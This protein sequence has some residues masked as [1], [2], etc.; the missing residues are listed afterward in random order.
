MSSRKLLNGRVVESPETVVE[1]ELALRALVS[2]Y[3]E[4][5]ANGGVLDF[6]RWVAHVLIYDELV[7]SSSLE[8]DAVRSLKHG[9]VIAFLSAAEMSYEKA[10][11][12]VLEPVSDSV[13]TK[14]AKSRKG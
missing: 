13:C 7:V 8:R 3:A 2:G 10:I 1:A 4:M 14:K 5:Y 6:L 12:V 11:G 9:K